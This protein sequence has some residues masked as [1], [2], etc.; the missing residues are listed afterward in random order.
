MAGSREEEVSGIVVQSGAGRHDGRL[1]PR[2]AAANPTEGRSGL[3]SQAETGS[4]V[5]SRVPARELGRAGAG[6]PPH[7]NTRTAVALHWIVA[8]TVLGMI[9]L[10][11]WMI[12]LPKDAGPFRAEMYNLHKSIAI[13]LGLINSAR[14]AWRSA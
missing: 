10:G 2:Y 3:S 1:V 13:T 8:I 14:I 7:G 4:L 12:N 11:L 9:G 6:A 5:S